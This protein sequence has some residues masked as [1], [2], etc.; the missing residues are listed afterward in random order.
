MSRTSSICARVCPRQLDE[1]ILSGKRVLA[2]RRDNR[3]GDA[4][5]ARHRNQRRLRVERIGHVHVRHDLVARLHQVVGHLVGADLGQPEVGFRIDQP[6]IHRHPL[7]VDHLRARRNLHRSRRSHGRDLAVL[8]HDHAV[9]DGAVRNRQ[10][11]AARNRDRL[12][13]NQS[14]RR[15]GFAVAIVFCCA[16]TVQ[17]ATSDERKAK[18]ERR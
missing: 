17:P 1:R 5:V 9:L 13:R 11:F 15:E 8:N 3:V 6:G 7:G 14:R 16:V 4:V 2:V 10:Q 12:A 18:S